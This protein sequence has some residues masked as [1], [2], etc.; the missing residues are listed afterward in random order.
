VAEGKISGARSKALQAAEKAA[1]D[2][3]AAEAAEAAEAERLAAETEVQGDHQVVPPTDPVMSAWLDYHG[4]AACL[5]QL[6]DISTRSVVLRRSVYAAMTRTQ[7]MTWLSQ[8]PGAFDE[9]CVDGA[10][11]SPE[12][13]E[14]LAGLRLAAAD[15][16]ASIAGCKTWQETHTRFCDVQ[17]QLVTLTLRVMSRLAQGSLVVGE[18]APQPLP[19]TGSVTTCVNEV[20]S[21]L[22]DL[23]DAVEFCGTEQENLRHGNLL[24]GDY[25]HA[26]TAVDE[27]ARCV[28][29][30]A[31]L[32]RQRKIVGATA[33]A[34]Y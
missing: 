34:C 7:R 1:A 30:V 26:V 11:Q 15:G 20:T 6:D 10:P 3:L 33:D 22:M 16:I 4:F 18:E 31:D 9:V 14:G 25:S 21:L 17:A 19:I 29:A 23:Y 28:Y 12:L 27:G 5:E 32:A 13:R 2:R 24:L 8:L